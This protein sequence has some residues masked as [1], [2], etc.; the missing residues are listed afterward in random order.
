MAKCNIVEQLPSPAQ[1]NAL[2]QAVGWKEYDEAVIA[3]ALPN[4]LYCVCA[5]VDEHIVG[6]A[7]VIGD[8][9][10][11][12]YVQDVIVLPEYQQQGIGRQMM[13]QVMSYIRTHARHNSII[14][15]MA[16]HGK[17]SFY[18]S[19]GFTRRPTE[20]LG[21]GMTMFWKDEKD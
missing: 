18:E 15:L 12:Y 4:T 8:G 13:A 7:R 17:E 14:G 19:Y 1:Y 3:D 6:M 10:L 11:V 20:R 5:F 9:G 16:A 21:A 2:R